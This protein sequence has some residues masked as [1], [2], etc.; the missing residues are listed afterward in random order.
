V[1][2]PKDFF[3]INYFV[4]RSLFFFQSPFHEAILIN[5]FGDSSQ[6]CNIWNLKKKKNNVAITFGP[7]FHRFFKLKM[8][9]QLFLFYNTEK[10]QRNYDFSF[11]FLKCFCQVAKF[12][13]NKKSVEKGP[14][15]KTQHKTQLEPWLKL[16]LKSQNK[17]QLKPRLKTQLKPRLKPP[18]KPGFKT[19]YETQL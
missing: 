14:M 16:G 5:I 15:L 11:F 3:L 18:L 19:W 4:M 1:Q 12:C 2:K 9:S 10:N 13:Q 7:I 8:T 17:T 6:R